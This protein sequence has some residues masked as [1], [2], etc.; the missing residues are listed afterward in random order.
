[1][2]ISP[3]R[4]VTQYVLP[5]VL[6]F[7]VFLI[8]WQLYAGGIKFGGTVL[9]KG[10][11]AYLVP[12]PLSVWNAA[13]EQ[14]AKL[15]TATWLTATGA[16]AGFAASIVVGALIA[17]VFSQSAIIQRAAYPYAIFLQTV[18]IVA[19]APL[20]ILWFGSGF[21]AIA[22]TAFVISLFPIIANGTQGLT[23]LDPQM[24]ELFAIHRATRM[25]KLMKLR[26]PNSIPYFVTGM[27]TSSGLS[28]IGGIV[29]EFFAGY[30]T[31]KFG[32]GYLIY[33]TSGQQKMDLLFAAIIASTLL[34]LGI[35]ALVGVASRLL[36]RRWV[37]RSGDG[38]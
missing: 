23:A 38:L 25:Q 24:V 31:E 12:K 1:M 3:A 27:R 14:H 19:I 33:Q 16:L 8:A 7:A 6:L 2:K 26:I 11:P 30:G 34:G 15:A 20:I 32:L 35:F 22:I 13:V 28:V 36:L 29:G 37:A 17:F 18:P 4:F 5:P 9:W 21:T 10:M